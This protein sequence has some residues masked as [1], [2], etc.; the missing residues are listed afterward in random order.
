MSSLDDE[1]GEM[2]VIGEFGEWLHCT[3]GQMEFYFHP[4]SKE[5]QLEQ[6]GSPSLAQ[7]LGKEN[8]Q[9]NGLPVAVA[10]KGPPQRDEPLSMASP[11]KED[12][13]P[14]GPDI[15][16]SK[17]KRVTA[18]LIV[19]S[20]TRAPGKEGFDA[21]ARQL[22]HLHLSQK[23]LTHLN[24]ESLP[25]RGVTTIYAYENRIAY[26]SGLGRLK[27][28]KLYLQDNDVFTLQDWSDDLPELRTL[29]FQNNR[30]PALDGLMRSHR[31]EEL[32]VNDQRIEQP[33]RLH[34]PTLRAIS[35]SLRMLDISRNGLTDV[36][37]LAVLTRLENL[38]AKD[39]CIASVKHGG[40]AEVLGSCRELE[41]IWL[42][43]NPL[44]NQRKYRD[45]VILNS[46]SVQE[47]DGK[48]VGKARS[49]L[50]ALHGRRISKLPE[51]SGDPVPD[52]GLGGGLP[53]FPSASGAPV[54]GGRPVPMRKALPG[55]MPRQPSLDGPPVADSPPSAPVPVPFQRAVGI[56]GR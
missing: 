42:M 37:P 43:G 52:S 18:E 1:M 5:V 26:V 4:V 11:H 38:T 45:Q 40:L 24:V 51:Q 41:K 25:V 55:M 3:D 29:H 20:A 15:P 54:R 53:A 56:R 13:K 16:V 17:Q 28:E 22:T 46:N 7:A 6:P 23:R 48:E 2:Q 9:E 39:N 30:V 35:P 8:C 44:T 27:L 10:E 33:L 21:W 31:L 32:L 14:G 47:I 49:F 36:A 19:A 34:L 12:D 50:H